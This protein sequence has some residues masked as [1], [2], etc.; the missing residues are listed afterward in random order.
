MGGDPSD[1]AD[2]AM[3]ET[4]HGMTDCGPQGQSGSAVRETLSAEEY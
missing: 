4:A 3:P 2:V 1:H